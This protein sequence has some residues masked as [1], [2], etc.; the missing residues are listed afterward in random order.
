[1]TQGI[2][3]TVVELKA[4]N[5]W[6]RRRSRVAGHIESVAHG[7][8]ATH[9]YAAVTV[10]DVAEAAGVSARTVAR[11]FTAKEDMLLALPRRMTEDAREG[12]EA[13]RGSADPVMGVWELFKEQAAR[14]NNQLPGVAL[15][16]RALHTAPDVAARVI[17]EQRREV[18]SVITELCADALGVDTAEDLR[19]S[20][21]ATTL[22]AANE[23]VCNFWMATGATRDLQ[24]LFD[25]A[26][27][28]L[29]SDIARLHRGRRPRAQAAGPLK[30]TRKAAGGRAAP[31]TPAASPVRKRTTRA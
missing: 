22:L 2:H 11:Y 16:V 28:S 12:L 15:W 10:A 21:L 18:M 6:D 9:G 13:L 27:G 8:F 24:E 7:L 19:P 29:A 23:A 1:M 3:V 17:G 25:E 26:R 30:A 31:R 20:L 14:G 4:E 5:G